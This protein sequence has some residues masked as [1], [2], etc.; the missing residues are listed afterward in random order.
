MGIESSVGLLSGAN[1][2]LGRVLGR[3]CNPSLAGHWQLKEE[4]LR[5]QEP[6][7]V[8]S[9]KDFKRR[10]ARDRRS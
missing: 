6:R 5:D 2:G 7:P 9:K 10:T 8:R 1:R 3:L 4:T